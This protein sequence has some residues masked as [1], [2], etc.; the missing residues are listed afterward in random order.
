MRALKDV[1]IKF[2]DKEASCTALFDTGS[3]YSRVLKKLKFSFTHL[4][5]GLY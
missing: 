2:M 5:N 4:L 1:K 3:G